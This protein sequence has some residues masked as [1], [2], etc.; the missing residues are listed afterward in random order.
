MRT[1]WQ[2][3]NETIEFDISADGEEEQ[4]YP[5]LLHKPDGGQ[6]SLFP[7]RFYSTGTVPGVPR[8]GYRFRTAIRIWISAT[9]LSKSLAMRL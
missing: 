1:D 2:I 3:Y 4:F 7:R 9:C 5:A 6:A 8:A